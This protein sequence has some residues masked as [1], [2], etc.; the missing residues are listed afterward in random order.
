M[1]NIWDYEQAGYSTEIFDIVKPVLVDIFKGELINVENSELD[2]G[3]CIDALVADTENNN[4]Y[5]IAFRARKKLYKD[6]TIRY[7]HKDS[8]TAKTEYDK[9]MDPDIKIKPKYHVQVNDAGSFY[10]LAIIKTSDII[11]YMTFNNLDIRT[12]KD[13]GKFIVIPWHNLK[14]QGYDIKAYRIPK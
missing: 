7:K 3:N 2:F 12:N 9:L 14:V 4:F 5:G 8:K 11:D 6:L 1:A 13:S 10:V